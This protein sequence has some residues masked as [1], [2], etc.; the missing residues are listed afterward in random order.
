AFVTQILIH[1]GEATGVRVE[2]RGRRTRRCRAARAVL[3][4]AGAIGTPK[5]LMLSGVGDPLI[6][7]EL[8]IPVKVANREVGQNLADHLAHFTWFG[9]QTDLPI[10]PLRD[11][12]CSSRE[13]CNAFFR[14]DMTSPHVDAELRL[15]GGC[16]VERNS[17]DFGL[18]SVLL[19]PA[20]RGRVTLRA[21]EPR[22]EPVVEFP[23]WWDEDYEHLEQILLRLADTLGLEANNLSS[24]TKPLKEDLREKA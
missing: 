2:R 11:A 24:S 1:R 17:F 7:Q 10:D 19:R 13:I 15:Y 14:S 16:N 5:L 6:L 12:A 9:L 3:L 18:E 20:S 23:R 4:A 22:A 21:A 8:D